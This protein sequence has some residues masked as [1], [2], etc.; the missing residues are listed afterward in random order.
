[1]LL[2]LLKVS[3]YVCLCGRPGDSFRAMSSE[4]QQPLPSFDDRAKMDTE[5]S[6]CF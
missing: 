2:A 5:V 4:Q 1:M 6:L 3:H